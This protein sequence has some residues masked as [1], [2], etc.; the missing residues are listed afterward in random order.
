MEA[1]AKWISREQSPRQ[2]LTSRRFLGGGGEVLT[3]S[4]HVEK[5]GREQDW[6]DWNAGLTDPLCSQAGL[7][8]R[9]EREA[10]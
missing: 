5:K 10:F 8:P 7:V 3:G 4:I 2:R 6:Q 9:W 1:Y